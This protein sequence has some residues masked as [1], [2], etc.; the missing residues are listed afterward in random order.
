L[1]VENHK[2]MFLILK[3]RTVSV[4]KIPSFHRNECL[5]NNILLPRNKTC[6]DQNLM[7][8]RASDLKEV[9]KKL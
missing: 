2:S 7:L 9:K 6:D 1:V 3:P 8:K 5:R 4:Y